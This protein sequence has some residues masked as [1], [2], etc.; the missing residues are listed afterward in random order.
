LQAHEDGISGIG[1][2]LRLGHIIPQILEGLL[3]I[4]AH[5]FSFQLNY[6]TEQAAE[7][8]LHWD[9]AHASS[10]HSLAARLITVGERPSTTGE[11]QHDGLGR[12]TERLLEC[13]SFGLARSRARSWM[14]ME[15][16]PSEI[17]RL[18]PQIDLVVE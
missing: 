11:N 14:G 4:I 7:R 13:G 18:T 5:L 6:R 2:L 17:S 15:P 3:K 1:R 9:F 12:T 10:V 8:Q 16:D